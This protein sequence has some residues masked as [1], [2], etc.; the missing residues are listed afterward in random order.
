MMLIISLFL[1]ITSTS[2]N[3]QLLPVFHLTHILT[4]PSTIFKSRLASLLFCIYLTVSPLNSLNP[5][6]LFL[7]WI[8]CA[9]YVELLSAAFISKPSIATSFLPHQGEIDLPAFKALQSMR[10]H[11][12]TRIPHNP[13]TSFGSGQFPQ[14]F[15][16]SPCSSCPRTIVYPLSFTRPHSTHPAKFLL[17]REPWASY[18]SL[19]KF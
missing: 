6:S 17:R 7:K 1:L 16:N 9:A 19:L 10:L 12:F 14:C 13:S 3:M 15:T 11:P 5:I 8:Y 2:P 18:I 4:V